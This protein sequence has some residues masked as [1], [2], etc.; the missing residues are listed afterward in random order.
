MLHNKLLSGL[1]FGSQ[2][3]QSN[4]SLYN[5]LVPRIM[6]MLFVILYHLQEFICFL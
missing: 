3:N 6:G 2:H 5:E 1:G 4:C